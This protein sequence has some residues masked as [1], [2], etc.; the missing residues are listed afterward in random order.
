MLSDLF[1]YSIAFLNDIGQQSGFNTGA[2][3]GQ[4]GTSQIGANP[5]GTGTGQQGERKFETYIRSMK[6][7]R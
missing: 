3:T 1:N 2:G 6:L 4:T 5:I 7:Q